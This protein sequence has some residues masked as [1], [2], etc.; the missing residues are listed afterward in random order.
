MFRV[1][2]RSFLLPSQDLFLSVL[3]PRNTS[4]RTG[5]TTTPTAE[6][7]LGWMR[8]DEWDSQMAQW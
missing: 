3:N 2:D 4:Q 7:E 5:R 8:K 1:T 6:L